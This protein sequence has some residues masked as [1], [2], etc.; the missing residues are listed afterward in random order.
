M[1]FFFFNFYFSLDF[2]VFPA[3]MSFSGIVFLNFVFVFFGLLLNSV[4]GKKENAFQMHANACKCIDTNIN[5]HKTSCIWPILMLFVSFFS[6]ISI[7]FV[8]TRRWKAK[9]E[10][11]YCT[12]KYEFVQCFLFTLLTV[13]LYRYED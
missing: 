6:F 4:S 12:T 3:G 1:F 2:L 13:W 10:S 7:Y 9:P 8:N 5:K 11:S